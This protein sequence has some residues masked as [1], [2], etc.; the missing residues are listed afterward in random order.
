MISGP[1]GTAHGT[2]PERSAIATSAERDE[3]WTFAS[4]DA[5][6]ARSVQ[7]GVVVSLERR[8]ATPDYTAMAQTILSELLGNIVRHAPGAVEVVLDRG[9][10]RPVLHVLDRGRGFS[11]T[12]RLP[13]DV[14]AESGR[15]L[16]MIHA[17]AAE[18]RIVPRRGGGSHA[19][20]VLAP[21]HAGA[22]I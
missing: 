6:G 8:G 11:F 10:R 7:D 13:I 14:L 12:P 9:L 16:F 22:H 15:G 3:R 1:D 18:F 5:D 2:R 17:L 4:S 20:V 21:I 19:I